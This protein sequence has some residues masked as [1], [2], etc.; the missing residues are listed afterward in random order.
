MDHGHCVFIDLGV[1]Q[2]QF[3]R[4]PMPHEIVAPGQNP[5]MGLLVMRLFGLIT[6]L[7]LLKKSWHDQ[8]TCRKYCSLTSDIVILLG[9]PY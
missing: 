3:A 5:E 8:P 7:A 6:P 9:G 1:Q 4:S 2:P